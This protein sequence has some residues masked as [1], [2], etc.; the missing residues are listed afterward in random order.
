[1][2]QVFCSARA[3]MFKS[4][5]S[6]EELLSE[7]NKRMMV[8]GHPL[9][10]WRSNGGPANYII[11][12]L[13]PSLSIEERSVIVDEYGFRDMYPVV[14]MVR[15]ATT[16]AFQLEAVVRKL[17]EEVNVGEKMGRS[18]LF[19]WVGSL[20]DVASSFGVRTASDTF[21]L[22]YEQAAGLA[23]KLGA[24]KKETK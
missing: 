9:D 19:E 11:S 14:S 18:D 6:R 12:V 17:Y 20:L 8:A 1:V 15:E 24:Y 5:F 3:E 13:D 16:L 2:S 23:V 21:A 4:R 7:I 22:S 10:A